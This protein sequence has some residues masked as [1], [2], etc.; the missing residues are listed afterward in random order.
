MKIGDSS[1]VAKTV[2][3]VQQ[4]D[5]PLGARVPSSGFARNPRA[6]HVGCGGP[7]TLRHSR[8]PQS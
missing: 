8:T 5:G 7:P 4:I 2:P 3:A 6:V 1:N